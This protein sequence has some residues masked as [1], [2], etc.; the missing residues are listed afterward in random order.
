[1]RSTATALETALQVLKLKTLPDDC[2]AL[3]KAVSPSVDAKTWT[4]THARAYRFLHLKL[5][6]Q[7]KHP[8][9]NG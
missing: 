5:A 8:T 4:W 9:T 6:K 1:M 2:R 7:H 3:A